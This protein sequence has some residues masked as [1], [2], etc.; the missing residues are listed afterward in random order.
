MRYPLTVYGSRLW[1]TPKPVLI[2]GSFRSAGCKF[3][4]CLVF[5]EH[6]SSTTK[7]HISCGN[8]RHV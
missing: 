4:I 7:H 5:A 8:V 3:T 6:V 1:L 2:I